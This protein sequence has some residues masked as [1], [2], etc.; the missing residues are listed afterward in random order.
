MQSLENRLMA[1]IA[2]ELGIPE[3]EVT[4]RSRFADDYGVDDFG[5]AGLA[6]RLNDEFDVTLSH[7]D[8]ESVGTV[9]DLI[10]L[11]RELAP[12]TT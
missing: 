6:L 12:Q 3:T 1:V 10:D 4:P 9:G 8:I 2:D 5:V 7:D 11:V